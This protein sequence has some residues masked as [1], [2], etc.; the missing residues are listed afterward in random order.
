MFWHEAAIKL[1]EE[2]LIHGAGHDVAM[3][4]FCCPENDFKNTRLAQ[5]D[6]IGFIAFDREHEIGPLPRLQHAVFE[7]KNHSR[8]KSIARLQKGL[9]SGLVH[10]CALIQVHR[11]DLVDG[12]DVS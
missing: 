2:L 4:G 3:I 7:E 11:F 6:V 5:I 9:R 10:V 8:F 12:N 1:V